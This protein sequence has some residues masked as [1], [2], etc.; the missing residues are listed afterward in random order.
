MQVTM[1]VEANDLASQEKATP[2]VMVG[3]PRPD[4]KCKAV[5]IN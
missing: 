4:L 2:P 3:F 1:M 5:E